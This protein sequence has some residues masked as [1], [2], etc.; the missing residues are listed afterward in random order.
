MMADSVPRR[1]GQVP[2]VVKRVQ[3]GFPADVLAD[4]EHEARA[5]RIHTSAEV[6]R[7]CAL[8]QEVLPSRT[9]TDWTSRHPATQQ[10][11]RWF[12]SD[13]LPAGPVRELS[14]IIANHA[15]YL[16]AVLPDGPEL[17]TGLRKMLEAKDCMVRAAIDAQ[18]PDS[19]ASP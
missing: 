9:Q 18:K 11:L 7:R 17:T 10:L 5:R 19:V 6:V 8:V 4:V 3:V 14:S 2:F 12:A 15:H 16:A 13:H 1:R